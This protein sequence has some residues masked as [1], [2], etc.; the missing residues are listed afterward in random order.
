MLC[1]II[2]EL[3]LIGVFNLWPK[4]P[5]KPREITKDRFSEE[6]TF[7]ENA[8]ITKQTTAPAAPPK[9]VVPV[10]VPN[11]VI[12]E[13]EIDFPDF[14]DIFTRYESD[15]V[16]GT[17]ETTGEGEIV[18]SPQQQ[19]GLLRIVEPTIPDAAKRANVK[20]RIEVTFLVGRKGEVEDF[21]ISEIRVYDGNDYEIVNDIG[22]GIMETVTEAA[23]KWR[24]T[25]ARDNGKAVRTYV[26][27]SFRIGF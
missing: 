18:G 7:V 13:E 23:S 25:P 27:N 2:A 10:P 26:V 4:Q 21:Y 6:I 20:A 15:G 8:I 9:P 16:E 5:Y 3:I 24:F 12:I 11:D 19:P 22:Y 1:L 17:A 14:D